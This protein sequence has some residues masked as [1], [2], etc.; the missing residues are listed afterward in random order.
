MTASAERTRITLRAWSMPVT[1]GTLTQRLASRASK[2][3]RRPTT[4]PPAWA[5]PREAA[6]ITPPRPPHGSTAPA[7]A[8]ARPTRSARAATRVPVGLVGAEPV[9]G[10]ALAAVGLEGGLVGPARG[11]AH[12]E[13]PLPARGQLAQPGAEAPRVGG[14]A[15]AR[16]PPRRVGDSRL[17]GHL[18]E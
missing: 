13:R 18:R 17:R 9:D 11:P 4:S 3:G 2:P 15:A 6:S 16:D 10:R 5:A 1:I 8:M 14:L 7:S 12:R